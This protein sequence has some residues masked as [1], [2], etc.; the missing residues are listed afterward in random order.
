MQ[1]YKYMY[2]YDLN[3]SRSVTTYLTLELTGTE[4]SLK[5]GTT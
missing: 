4:Y 5:H 3:V 2:L 1:H